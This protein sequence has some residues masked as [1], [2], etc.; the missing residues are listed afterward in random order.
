MF[1]AIGYTWEHDTHLYWRRATSLA[2]SLGPTTRWAREA[3]ELAR[4]LKRSTAINLGDVESDFRARVA[5]TLD[6]ALALP[7]ENPTDDAR[8]PGLAYGSQRDLLVEGGSGRPAPA[9]AV[10][11]RRLAG[12]AGHHRRGVRQTPGVDQALARHRGVDPADD[13]RQRVRRAARTLRVADP[14]RHPAVVPVVQRTGRRFGPGVAEHP[15]P[16]GRRRMAGQ[17]AQDLDLVRRT[18][19]QFGALLA[20]TDPDASKHRGISYFLVDMTSPGIEVCPIKQASGHF[21]FNEV[22]LTDVFVPDD[23]LVGEPGDG[24]DLAV[25]TMAV[26]RTAIGNYVNIDRS[27]ALRHMA[28]DRRTRSR[29]DAAGARRDR[30]AHHRDQGHG[31]ARN[32]APGAGTGCRAGVEHRQV[33]DGDAAAPRLDRD[34]GPHRTSRDAGGFRS[35][36]DQLR[37]STCHPSSS[38]A[39]Q[40]RSS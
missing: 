34:A 28:D 3:G 36:G 5:E 13:S 38:A 4:T 18:G 16:E 10:G 9:A 24:W 39:A 11:R 12:A 32:P 26:E 1:G 14:A 27:E 19:A 33:R 40:Q 30:G 23:M 21:D 17:R 2:A 29:R 7:N 8:A 22:F 6:R 37:T 20:R 31:A 25:A 35:P 15:R